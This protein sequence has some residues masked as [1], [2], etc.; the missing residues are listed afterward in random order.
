MRKTIMVFV[1]LTEDP[2]E[3]RM[4]IEQVDDNNACSFSMH[5]EN[6][7]AAHDIYE[8]LTNGMK[9]IER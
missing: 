6:G 3:T 7:F 2:N 1:D 5:T 9:G 8:L 4:C